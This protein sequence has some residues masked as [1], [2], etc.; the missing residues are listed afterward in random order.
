VRPFADHFS[1]IAAAYAAARP[2][3][4]AALFR[5]LAGQAPGRRCAW[6]C[7]AGNGQASLPLAELFDTVVA[8]DASGAQLAE[9]PARPNVRRLTAPAE[10]SGL[11]AGSTDLVTV[12]QALHWL[13]L[14]RFWGE[15]RRVLVDGGIVA[16]WCYGIQQVDQPEVDRE[17]RR[18]YQ[19]VVGPYWAPERRLVETG[20]A[21]L[22]FPFEP[23]AA[24][25]F[26]MAVDW[27]LDQFLAYVGTWS[28]TNRL[29]AEQEIDPLPELAQS[30]APWW[31]DDCRRVQWPLSLRVGRSRHLV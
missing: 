13:P 7:A 11:P 5:W 18:F 8:T 25:P 24:P 30:L 23:V 6:D 31:G 9:M 27:R 19:E 12:A 20:Y 28:A 15:V 10:A 3:Y 17:V 4:P 22:Q 1:D 29:R 2:T 26:A 14:E 21:T 16:A